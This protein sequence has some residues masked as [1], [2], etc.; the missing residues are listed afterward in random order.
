MDP[1]NT[2]LLAC[3]STVLPLDGPA[4]PPC[5]NPLNEGTTEAPGESEPPRPT[6]DDDEV[7]TGA[8]GAYL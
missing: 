5:V 8:G 4:T 1:D 6:P 2:S 3:F 7:I